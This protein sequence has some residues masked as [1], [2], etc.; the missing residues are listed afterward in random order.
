MYTIKILNIP[1]QQ[2]LLVAQFTTSSAKHIK[3]QGLNILFLR[4]P[5][6]L[7]RHHTPKVKLRLPYYSLLVNW[8]LG[9]WRGG[10]SNI[11]RISLTNYA[12]RP[13]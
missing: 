9:S 6:K 12:A 7:P 3:I 1:P 8:L 2:N 5:K 11:G 13:P 4:I 10:K